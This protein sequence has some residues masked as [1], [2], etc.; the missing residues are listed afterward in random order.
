[1]EQTE[2]AIE[3]IFRAAGLSPHDQAKVAALPAA[4]RAGVA[5]R[6]M[7]QIPQP[8]PQPT[9][10][11]TWSYYGRAAAQAPTPQSR[12]PAGCPRCALPLHDCICHKIMK[13]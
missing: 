11:T 8:A 3:A 4:V 12:V 13:G 1:M 6:L 9:P 2:E 10:T 7:P 5:R